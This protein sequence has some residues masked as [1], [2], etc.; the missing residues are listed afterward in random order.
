MSIPCQELNKSP[1]LGCCG[2]V[3][4]VQKKSL[5]VIQVFLILDL[6]MSEI[7]SRLLFLTDKW[8]TKEFTKTHAIQVY[9]HVAILWT[10]GVKIKMMILA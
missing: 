8:T 5:S 2:N 3:T 9:G 7:K 10:N 6:D 4:S 1:I